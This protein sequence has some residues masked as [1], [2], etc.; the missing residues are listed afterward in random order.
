MGVFFLRE[1]L[2]GSY[3]KNKAYYFIGE[4]GGVAGKK[5]SDADH[6]IT[7]DV[8]QTAQAF[9]TLEHSAATLGGM[10]T[11]PSM[12]L[13]PADHRRAAPPSTA[14]HRLL[15]ALM[16]LG[17]L[18]LLLVLYIAKYGPPRRRSWWGLGRRSSSSTSGSATWRSQPSGC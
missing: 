6:R 5:L 1:V 9:S 7:D 3:F 11:P 16:A 10:P 4:G 14:A 17:F 13:L 18:P 15:H 2:H 12:A 8:K